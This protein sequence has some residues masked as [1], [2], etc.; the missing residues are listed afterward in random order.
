[1]P[2]QSYPVLTAKW[3]CVEKCPL[4]LPALFLVLWPSFSP[5]NKTPQNNPE[6]FTGVWGAAPPR[7]IASWRLSCGVIMMYWHHD[8]A[9]QATWSVLHCRITPNDCYCTL[10][11]I[12]LKDDTN[13]A[14]TKNN[15]R[16]KLLLA[17]S[18]NS[19][20]TIKWLKQTYLDS[21]P[22]MRSCNKVPCLSKSRKCTN[23][24]SMWH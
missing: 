7:K 12:I 4:F 23:C 21:F 9:W 16:V 5:Q 24:T 17:K 20:N 3:L 18:T 19:G 15:S 13:M 1:M 14:S 8:L 11:C 2:E 10:R 22:S 6:F